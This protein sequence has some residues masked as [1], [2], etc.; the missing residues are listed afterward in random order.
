MRWALT[1]PFR[2]MQI[3]INPVSYSARGYTVRF[4][5]SRS[6][7]I[8]LTINET[9]TI[10]QSSRAVLA[11]R[12]LT[13]RNLIEPFLPPM[14]RSLDSATRHVYGWVFGSFTH[15]TKWFPFDNY[16]GLFDF[17]RPLSFGFVITTRDTIFDQRVNHSI[18]EAMCITRFLLSLKSLAINEHRLSERVV[19]SSSYSCCVFFSVLGVL[20]PF[21]CS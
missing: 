1:L 15:T 12:A 3:V 21:F 5:C 6:A 7:F 13:F 14:N 16:S 9:G 20:S 2:A 10:C 19:R 4:S 11:S 17:H 18:R 8:S